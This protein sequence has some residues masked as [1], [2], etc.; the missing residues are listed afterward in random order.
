M[1]KIEKIHR[2]INDSFRDHLKEA[3]ADKGVAVESE[4]NF[5]IGNLVTKTVDGKDMTPE[6]MEFLKGYSEG[7]ASAMRQVFLV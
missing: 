6:Q 2:Q 5:M 7:Y 4:W 3:M 1:T